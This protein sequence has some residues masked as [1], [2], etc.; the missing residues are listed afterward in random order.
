MDRVRILRII[1]YE[2]PR[3]W[4]EKTIR[5][6]IHGTKVITSLT[7]QGGGNITAVTLGEFPEILNQEQQETKED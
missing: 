7:I 5:D 4:V 2:G 6:S 3:H 1:A